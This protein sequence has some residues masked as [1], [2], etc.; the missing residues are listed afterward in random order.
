MDSKAAL[1]PRKHHCILFPRPARQRAE[2]GGGGRAR[3]QQSDEEKEGGKLIK[4]RRESLTALFVFAKCSESEA[5]AQR[6][7]ADIQCT[8]E[9]SYRTGREQAEIEGK[10][11]AAGHD[12]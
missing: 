5:T 10:A 4:G 11:G 1:V 9:L 7:G 3:E 2:G 6:K 12:G 8:Q